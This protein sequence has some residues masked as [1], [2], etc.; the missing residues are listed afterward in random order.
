MS[1]SNDGVSNLEKLIREKHRLQTFCSYQEKLLIYKFEEIKQNFPEILTN[2]LL[3][4]SPEKN[5]G[6]TSALDFANDFIIRFL[7]ER[8]RKNKLTGLALKVLQIIIIRAFSNKAEK[9][10]ESKNPE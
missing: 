7:P 10:P 3:P 4:Y 2:E 1:K 6:I 8:Y 5:K 9:K